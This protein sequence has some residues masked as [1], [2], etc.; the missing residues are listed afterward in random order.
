MRDVA[1]CPNKGDLMFSRHFTRQDLADRYNR[2]RKT[3]KRWSENGTLPKPAF[4]ING[5]DYWDA[6]VIEEADRARKVDQDHVQT[7]NLPHPQPAAD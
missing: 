4:S 5:Y 1:R 2:T 6:E 7:R 3:I